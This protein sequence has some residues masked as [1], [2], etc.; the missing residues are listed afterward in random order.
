[1]ATHGEE[2]VTVR[3]RCVVTDLDW[4]LTGNDL[5]LDQASLER[6][7]ALRIRG[8]AV[9]IASGRRLEEL[10][11]MGL[12]ARVDGLVAE[13]GSM[14]CVPR[15]GIQQTV[16]P[17]FRDAARAALGEMSASFRWGHVVGSGPRALA[18]A[19][20]ARLAR[21]DVAH[22]LEYN[23]EEV[24]ILPA[25]VTK[26]TGVARVLAQMRISPS[27]AWAIGDGENDVAMLRLVA[28]GAAPANASP[29]A[30]G[31]ADVLLAASH[32]AAFLVFTDPLL[33]SS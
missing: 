20:S 25:G 3:P 18:H 26:A 23:A 16:D 6:I 27:E 8:L 15:D 21:S 30:R 22:T 5:E 13:N 4:T 11:G 10:V 7:A 1:M 12:D 31:A 9:V 19:A 2:V 28:V 24:M 14:L 17:A 29:A 32:G 33:E